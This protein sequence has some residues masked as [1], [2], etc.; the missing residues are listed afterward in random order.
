MSRALVALEAV[1]GLGALIGAVILGVA[2]V[3]AGGGP[4]VLPDGTALD[5]PV[6]HGPW[7]VSSYVLAAA[8]ALLLIDAAA[9]LYRRRTDRPAH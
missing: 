9:R 8:A 6:F 7:I 4:N 1:V 3:G 5:T 2:G